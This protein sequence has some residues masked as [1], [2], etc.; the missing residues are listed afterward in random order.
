MVMKRTLLIAGVS[1]AILCGS[2]V[3]ADSGLD[4]HK[5]AGGGGSSTGG[6]FSISGTIGQHD[7]GGP[8]SGGNFSVTGGFWAL[9]QIVQAPGA[10]TLYIS[11]SGNSVLVFW[12]D[13]GSWTLQQNG[14][15]AVTNGWSD[16]SG[17]T[18][19]NGTNYLTIPN[20]TGRHFFRLH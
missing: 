15:L 10:P 19:V 2:P 5:I 6:T 7:A 14:D 20:P 4:W 18:T 8:M 3:S 16:S 17:I 12:Q 1:A 13:V 11:H 9:I